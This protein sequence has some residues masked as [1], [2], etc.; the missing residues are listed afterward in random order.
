MGYWV[1]SLIGGVVGD[2]TITKEE[3]EG[4]MAGLL[5]VDSP[6]AGE[7]RL[8]NWVREHADTLGKQYANELGR[9]K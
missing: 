7:T 2:V 6:P 1:G 4:L 3:I 5:Y 8:T 9:R